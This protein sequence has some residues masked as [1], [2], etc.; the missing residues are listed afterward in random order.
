MRWEDFSKM[1]A[2]QRQFILKYAGTDYRRF[3][4]GRAVF[5][6]SEC[7]NR[8]CE[9]FISTALRDYES[10]EPWV[11]QARDFRKYP[12]RYWDPLID[13][14]RDAEMYSRFTVFY[15]NNGKNTYVAESVATFNKF[16][17]VAGRYDSVVSD[18]RVKQLS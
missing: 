2:K 13:T 11:I 18:I 16:W 8:K 5:N 10:G 4:S 6:L 1:S 12:V 9:R 7:S 3:G 15:R 14:M 17:K